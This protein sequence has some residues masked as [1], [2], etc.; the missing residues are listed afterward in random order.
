MEARSP[1]GGGFGSGT[2]NRASVRD[3]AAANR[4]TSWPAATKPSVSTDTT[5]SMPPYPLG[6][7]ASH[8]GA[9]MP[10]RSRAPLEGSD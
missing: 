3:P 7:T 4:V 9:T 2:T 8:A 10:M 5:R 1:S 6:G